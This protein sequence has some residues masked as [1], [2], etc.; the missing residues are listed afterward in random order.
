[1][2]L[3][4]CETCGTPFHVQDGEEWKRLCLP[5][6]RASKTGYWRPTGEAERLREELETT[7]LVLNV[8]ELRIAQL[9]AKLARTA[10]VELDPAML[11]LLTQL[12]HPDRHDNSAAS[13]RAMAY[14]ND[15][16]RARR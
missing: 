4:Y 7:R 8:A 2:A 1:V 3:N 5:C 15:L 9:E 12:V 10:N 16:R 13:N 14:L 6:W 11:K